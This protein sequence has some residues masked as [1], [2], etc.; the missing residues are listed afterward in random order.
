[1]NRFDL[2][3]LSVIRLAEARSLLAAGHPSGAYYLAGYAVECALKARIAS[4]TQQYD[5][6]DK[7]KAQEAF[8]HRFEQLIGTA[9]LQSELKLELQQE[10]DFATFW[11]VA[12]NWRETGRYKEYSRPQAEEFLTAL[13]DQDHGVLSWLKRYW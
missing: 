10:P 8:T 5:F 12:I 13:D 9:G 6:P 11:E 3:R 1:M 7:G 4:F 2:Q